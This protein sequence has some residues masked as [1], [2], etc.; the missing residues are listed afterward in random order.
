MIKAIIIGVLCVFLLFTYCLAVAAKRADED[1]EDLYYADE[2][3][4]SG[5]GR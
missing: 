2:E 5:K 1:L 3:R 4:N